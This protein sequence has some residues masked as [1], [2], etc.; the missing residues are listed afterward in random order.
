VEIMQNR[1]RV[2]RRRNALSDAKR[3]LYNG[4][5]FDGSGGYC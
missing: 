1:M 2:L 4:A 3:A 5:L